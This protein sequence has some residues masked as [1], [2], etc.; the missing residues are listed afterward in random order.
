LLK[1]GNISESEALRK[2]NVEAALIRIINDWI[3][4]IQPG[5]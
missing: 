5:Q 4:R 3:W 2:A 1:A